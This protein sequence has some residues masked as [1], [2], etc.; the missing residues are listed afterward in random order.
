MDSFLQQR[1]YRSSWHSA[2][3]KLIYCYKRKGC[4]TNSLNH[5]LICM[6]PSASKYMD[7][8]HN[9][10]SAGAFASYSLPI[11]FQTSPF[12]WVALSLSRSGRL[13]WIGTESFSQKD[14][15]K[16]D[17]KEFFSCV[18]IDFQRVFDAVLIIYSLLEKSSLFLNRRLTSEIK[19]VSIAKPKT[20]CLRM[21]V[22]IKID[23]EPD[24]SSSRQL[25]KSVYLL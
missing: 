5:R 23:T 3:V 4:R 11:W 7:R 12:L 9:W 2:N 21:W 13:K 20:V 22:W 15:R 16:K 25:H 14:N 6:T 8:E 18:W 10:L 19:G 17:N 24:G 1:K